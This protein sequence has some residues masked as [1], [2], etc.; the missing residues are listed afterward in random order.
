MDQYGYLALAQAVCLCRRGIV[1][2]VDAL[3]LDEVVAGSHRPELIA[4]T[5]TR[6]RRDRLRIGAREA[7]LGLGAL[8]VS[9]V[10]RDDAAAF[11]EYPVD[12]DPLAA[13]LAGP[14]RHCAR[15]LVQEGLPPVA[16]LLGAQRQREQ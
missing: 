2:P 1:Q 4:T 12:V 11:P 7:P 8:D 9:R 15:D 16:Q 5:L 6:A 14:G 13:F 3:D 10:L